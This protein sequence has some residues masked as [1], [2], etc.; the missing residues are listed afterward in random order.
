MTRSLTAIVGE[1]SVDRLVAGIPLVSRRRGHAVLHPLWGPALRAVVDADEVVRARVE[2]AHVHRAAGRFDQAIQLQLDAESWEHALATIREVAIGPAFW[3]SRD[4]LGRWSRALPPM[5]RSR[6]EATLAAGLAQRAQ[7]PIA[8]LAAIA[9]AAQGFAA[10]GDV[11]AEVAAMAHEAVVHWWANDVERIAA[12]VPR[13]QALAA[14]GSVSAALML[15]IGAAAMAQVSGDAAAVL[16]ALDGVTAQV[17]T[18]W[19]PVVLWLRSVARRQL[20]DLRGARQEFLADGDHVEENL[21]RNQFELNNWRTDWLEGDVDQVCARVGG[22]CDRYRASGDDFFHVQTV[23]EFA[24]H[25]AWL[26][27]SAHA[28]ELIEA[29]DTEARR[30]PGS[31]LHVL[32]TVANV[33]IAIDRDEDDVA[34]AIIRAETKA[35][36]F[37]ADLWFWR[38]RGAMAL[39]HVLED[40]PPDG[41][42]AG[43]LGEAMRAVRR[44]DTSVIA[45]TPWPA[46]GVARANLPHRWLLELCAASIAVGNPPPAELVERFDTDIRQAAARLATSSPHETTRAGAARA[47]NA[48]PPAPRASLAIRV[49]GPLEV[50]LDGTFVDH[51]HLHRQRVRELLTTLVVRRKVRREQVAAYLWPELANAAHNL[52]VTLNYLQQV[53][54]PA[55]RSPEPPYFVRA[56]G[57]WLTLVDNS[58]ISVDLWVLNRHLDDGERCDREGDPQATIERF[59]AALP[60]WRGEAFTDLPDTDWAWAERTHVTERYASAATRTA[61]LELAAGRHAEA[62]RSAAHALQADLTNESAYRVLIRARLALGDVSGAHRALAECRIALATLDLVPQAATTALLAP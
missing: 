36:S 2:A 52:R 35:P 30:M 37:R 48:I 31:L 16:A 43:A 42:T 49:L 58:R 12:L 32:R 50:A 26:G 20:G 9:T 55:R 28:A 21:D 19:L 23:S 8:S 29:T 41:R 3:A 57:D 62:M 34:A 61:E 59:E 39:F 10:A 18:R 60:L 24:A 6:P 1:R 15:S 22:L 38:D 53:L 51:P 45:S 13:M 25:E 33:A 7:D 44:G 46:A 54:Q 11:E 27:R 40:V 14:D 5:C 17:N 47:M 56:E 4:Q